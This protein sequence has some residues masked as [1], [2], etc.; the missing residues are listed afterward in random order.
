MSSIHTTKNIYE[1]WI[2]VLMAFG[3]IAIFKYMQYLSSEIIINFDYSIF[4]DSNT[5]TI[6]FEINFG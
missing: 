2:Y 1:C 5:M 3:T 4:D 6:R